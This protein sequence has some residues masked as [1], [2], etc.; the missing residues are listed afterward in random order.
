MFQLQKQRGV[1][2]GSWFSLES[3]LTPSLFEKANEP[4]GSEY[5]VVSALS[6]DN[7]RVLL[8][9][10]WDNFINDGDWSVRRYN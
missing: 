8:E 1:N 2:L 9:K 7:A 4:K 5:D 10:H 6:T 3:W